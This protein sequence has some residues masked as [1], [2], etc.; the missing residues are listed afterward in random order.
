MAGEK[1]FPAIID[2]DPG[3]DDALALA[4]AMASSEMELRAVTTVHG[5]IPLRMA[6]RNARRM[7][8]FLHENLKQ[9]GL[10]PP[11]YAGAGKPIRRGRIDRTISYAIHGKDGLGDLFQKRALPALGTNNDSRSADQVIADLAREYGKALRIIAIGPLTNL[12]LALKRDR[13]AL[14]G[15]G[16][17]VVMGGAARMPGNATA[18]AEFNVHCDPEATEVVMNCGA[19][20]TM[21]G[22]DVTRQAFLPSASLKGGGPFRKALRELVSPYA[23]FSKIRRGVDGVVLHDPLAVAAAI[24]PGLLDTLRRPVSVECGTGPAR[25]MTVVDLRAGAGVSSKAAPG[26]DVALGVDAKRFLRFFLK[27]LGAYRGWV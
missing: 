12:A 18:A 1:V 2:C 27:R 22:L 3:V 10:A 24:E 17:V 21:V 7:V 5:N 15:V 14:A 19:P 23:R 16:R 20:I 25:G 4:L 13:Y 26:V 9:P 6:H 11:V 8:S